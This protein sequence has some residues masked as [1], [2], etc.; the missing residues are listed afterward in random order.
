MRR[1]AAHARPA[2]KPRAGALGDLP[3]ADAGLLDRLKAWRLAEARAQ[4]VPAFV[5]LH[6]S[7]LG[8]IARRRPSDLAT[9]AGVA[10]IGAR[11]R[12]RYGAALLDTVNAANQDR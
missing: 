1:V 3:A 12:E 2:K 11:K 8:E 6:D 9:L 5:I 10:G 7:T 4:S